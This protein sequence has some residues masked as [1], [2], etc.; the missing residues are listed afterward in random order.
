MANAVIS[1]EPYLPTWLS[2]VRLTSSRLMLAATLWLSALAWFRPLA[3]P[4]EGR[5]TDI[6]RWMAVSGDW[7]VPRINGLPFLHKPPLYFWLEAIAI[8]TFGTSAFVARLVPLASAITICVC[9]FCLVRRFANEQAARWS[10]AVL[11]LNPLFYGGA[12]FANLDM[13]VAAMITLTITLAVLAAREPGHLLWIAAYGAAGLA[14]LAKGL[15][16][17]VL[18][19][20]V[21]VL[22]ALLERRPDWMLKALSIVGI[23]LFIAIVLPWFYIVEG[24]IPGFVHYFIV[25][26]HLERFL[27]SGFNNQQGLWFYPAVLFAAMLPWTAASL[28]RW[29][30]F[31]RERAFGPTLQN[32]GAVWFAV[33]LVFFSIPRSKLVGYILPALPAFAMLIG[34]WMAQYPRRRIT[35][36]IGAIVCVI[37]TLVAAFAQP[38]GPVHAAAQVKREMKPSDN[39]VF[40]GRYFFDVAVVLNRRRPIYIVGDW[41]KPSAEIPDNLRRQF[42]EGREFDSQ[43][44]YVLLDQSELEP[45]LN[46]ERTTWILAERNDMAAV[47]LLD[48]LTTV[49]V[50][51][52]FVVLRKNSG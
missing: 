35:A 10:V 41:S 45:L 12:Q 51:R 27:S 52:T 26:H 28:P 4:D 38:S 46:S 8:S 17:V 9:V 30:S 48:K 31:Y 42:T 34:P 49:A 19:G 15:I 11:A 24:T 20:A 33:V 2:R 43:A 47:S 18:P 7:F 14:V 40:I 44:G 21:F 32:L 29:R 1:V 5:Y 39:V 3:I 16:G 23:V 13:L 37:A 22:W 50:E 25:Y 36:T 6:S